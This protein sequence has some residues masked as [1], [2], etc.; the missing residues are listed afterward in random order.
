MNKNIKNILR[1][2]LIRINIQH[3]EL[4][5]LI[6]KSIKQNN[7]IKNFL[8]IYSNF[9]YINTLSS[10]NSISKKHKICILTGKKSGLFKNFSFSRYIIKSLILRGK[11]TNL[12]KKN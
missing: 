7:N 9:K 11:F 3:L 1:E 4:T 2:K 6:L 5:N 10:N 12:K 8:K